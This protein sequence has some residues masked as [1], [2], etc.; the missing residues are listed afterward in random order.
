M[1]K[2]VK[3]RL[4]DNRFKEEERQF[5]ADFICISPDEN[6]LY[7]NFIETYRFMPD[8]NIKCAT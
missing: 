4:L 1:D 5:R 6:F 2:S 7:R 3:W 8:C